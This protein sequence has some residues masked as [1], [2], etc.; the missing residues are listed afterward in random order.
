MKKKLLLTLLSLFSLSLASC[1]QQILDTDYKFDKAH[2]VSEH[3]CVEIAQW[4]NYENSDMV[5]IKLKDGSILLGYPTEIV[6]VK[7]T[8]PYCG[9]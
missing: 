9:K 2:L 1:N 8:C 3:K 4:N 7:G 5:Q 6:L